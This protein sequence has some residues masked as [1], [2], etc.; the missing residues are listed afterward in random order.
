MSGSP[1]PDDVDA[2]IGNSSWTDVKCNECNQYGGPVV[3]LGE[4]YDYESATA[5]ICEPCLRKALALFEQ[6]K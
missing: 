2:V 6:N 4:E 3:T 5:S 1:N